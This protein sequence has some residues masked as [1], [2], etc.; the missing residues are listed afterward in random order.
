[1]ATRTRLLGIAALALMFVSPA[2][3]WQGEGDTGSGGSAYGQG[4]PTASPTGNGG[5][6]PPANS[7]RDLG[8]TGGSGNRC[9]NSAVR[10]PK[11]GSAPGSNGAN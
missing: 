4:G 2:W 1:M 3:A 10:D 6:P 11:P 7:L 9:C 5:V 8:D